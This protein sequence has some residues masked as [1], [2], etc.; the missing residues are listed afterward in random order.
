ML[1]P[2]RSISF[3][4][5]QDWLC[6]HY[7]LVLS[8]QLEAAYGQL[9]PELTIQN[10]TSIVQTGDTHI[11]VYDLT[12]LVM[13]VSFVAKP[14]STDPNPQMAYDRQFTR[15]DM[16]ALFAQPAPPVDGSV[17]PVMPPARAE[18]PAKA[19]LGAPKPK[20]HA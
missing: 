10:I 13:Y 11:A 19:L 1:V 5:P 4:S 20:Q 6:P 3:S 15:L 9:T 8:Q 7:S 12:D 14:N 2:F 16:N 18:K 17:V